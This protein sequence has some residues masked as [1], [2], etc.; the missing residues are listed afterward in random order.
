MSV[1]LGSVRDS[2][3]LTASN[4]VALLKE[5]EEDEFEFER[6]KRKIK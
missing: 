4:Q 1:Y 5:K 2:R 6:R 3:L